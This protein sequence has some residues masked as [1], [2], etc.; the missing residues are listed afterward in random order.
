V[1]IT[2]YKVSHQ[3]PQGLVG[4]ERRQFL[5]TEHRPIAQRDV[6]PVELVALSFGRDKFLP[7][8]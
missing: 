8:V 4:E 5:G 6:L 1:V 3:I 7:L 2:P